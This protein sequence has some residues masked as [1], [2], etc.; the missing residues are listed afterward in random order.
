LSL[1]VVTTY[2]AF[3]SIEEVA[4]NRKDPRLKPQRLMRFWYLLQGQSPHL[5]RKEVLRFW[6]KE[7]GHTQKSLELNLRQGRGLYWELVGDQVRIFGEEEIA[8]ALGIELIAQV[9][10]RAALRSKT[11]DW[12]TH[13]VVHSIC[14]FYQDETGL[15]DNVS[16]Q[17]LSRDTGL[18]CKTVNR[19]IRC[20]KK[21][22]EL[23]II[24]QWV[25][26]DEKEGRATLAH[27]RKCLPKA[28]IRGMPRQSGVFRRLPDRFLYHGSSPPQ[29]GYR[30]TKTGKTLR[31]G[32]L[33]PVTHTIRNRQIWDGTLHP[34][35]DVYLANQRT[36][37]RTNSDGHP[38]NH[39]QRHPGQGATAGA[40]RHDRRQYV[41]GEHSRV[42]V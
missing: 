40:Q 42:D 7:L 36:K 24:Q 16:R 35:E 12:H 25:K 15:T 26:L 28:Y 6:E 3:P 14:S 2:V 1:L 38:S 17:D 41:A 22:G 13:V 10:E 11:V 23:D 31:R 8:Q 19:H 20:L 32:L 30:Q 18:S 37:I 9:R 39:L 27:W 5:T 33:P 4:F 21:S 34:L 29:K